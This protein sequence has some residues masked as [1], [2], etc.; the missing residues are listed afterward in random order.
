MVLNLIN[1]ACTGS[2]W[3]SC[4]S[5]EYNPGEEDSVLSVDDQKEVFGNISREFM[6]VD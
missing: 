2:V 3:V 1:G 4:N 5:I 6:D